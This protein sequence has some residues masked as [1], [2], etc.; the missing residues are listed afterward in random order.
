MKFVK[1]SY[2]TLEEARIAVD[3]VVAEGYDRTLITLITN[4][5]TADT[6]PTDLNVGVSTEHSE[7]HGQDDESFMDKVKHIFSADDNEDVNS[8]DE[9]Y[10]ADE[11][12]LRDFKDDI[13]N[14]S[15]V[16]LV[17]DFGVEPGAKDFDNSTPSGKM[18]TNATPL[19]SDTLDTTDTLD[20][21]D[22][23][24]SINRQ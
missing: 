4:R 8:T 2:L 9:G 12:V 7:K 21:I 3:E 18:E 1:G 10:E 16:V 14:G 13:T 23:T 15:I 11:S 20:T 5:E 22:K 24:D 17:D 19:P 6:F